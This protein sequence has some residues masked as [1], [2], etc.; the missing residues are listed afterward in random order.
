MFRF[1]DQD[2][3]AV[4]AADAVGK[5]PFLKAVNKTTKCHSFYVNNT[6]TSCYSSHL[7]FNMLPS[8]HQCH[9]GHNNLTI[10][11]LLCKTG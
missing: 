7:T 4:D 8:L 2:V 5:V 6:H 3:F 9:I 1:L 10:N 11:T